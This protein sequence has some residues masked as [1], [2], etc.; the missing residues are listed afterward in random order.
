MAVM[1]IGTGLADW[2]EWNYRRVS[3]NL[4]IIR[5]FFTLRRTHVHGVLHLQPYYFVKNTYRLDFEDI[6]GLGNSQPIQQKCT[7]ERDTSL[8]TR[9]VLLNKSDGGTVVGFSWLDAPS[10]APFR[11][12]PN[13]FRTHPFTLRWICRRLHCPH[14]YDDYILFLQ[15][16]WCRDVRSFLDGLLKSPRPSVRMK[17]W[18]NVWSCTKVSIAESF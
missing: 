10:C 2:R 1:K 5:K 4:V 7:W 9:A 15:R 12:T 13:S 16:T 6:L 17:E 14:K 3:C 18:Q 11:P 8:Y